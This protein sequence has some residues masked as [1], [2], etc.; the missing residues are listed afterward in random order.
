M[1]W[2]KSGIFNE[3]VLNTRGDTL[4]GAASDGNPAVSGS[5]IL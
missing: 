4:S 3:L 1:F 2:S 5:K